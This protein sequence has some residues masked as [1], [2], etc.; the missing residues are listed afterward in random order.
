MRAHC[1]LVVLSIYY[2]YLDV[3]VFG[4][5]GWVRGALG[6]RSRFLFKFKLQNDLGQPTTN[7]VGQQNYYFKN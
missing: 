2:M 5:A 4:K 3:G 6:G 1:V 7:L